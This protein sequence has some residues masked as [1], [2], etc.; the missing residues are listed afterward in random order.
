MFST[1]PLPRSKGDIPQWRLDDLSLHPLQLSPLSH[2]GQ[3]LE[4][5]MAE[6][7]V[8]RPDQITEG[9]AVVNGKIQVVWLIN[10]LC[11]WDWDRIHEGPNHNYA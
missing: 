2:D 7:K 6:H 5:F 11:P 1:F 9:F 10:G 4:E 8:A 3:T